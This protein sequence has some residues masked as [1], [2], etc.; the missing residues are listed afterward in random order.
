MPLPRSYSLG[1][2]FPLI[3]SRS[4]NSRGVRRFGF[5]LG[6]ATCSFLATDKEDTSFF[7]SLLFFFFFLILICNLGLRIRSPKIIL[8][9]NVC[10]DAQLAA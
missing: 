9:D 10:E 1:P 7:K 8:E 3:T 5:S 2:S 6:F 4:S